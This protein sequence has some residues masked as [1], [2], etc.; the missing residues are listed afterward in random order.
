MAKKRD[1][2]T[3]APQDTKPA[4]AS[5][6]TREDLAKLIGVL[7]LDHS[8]SQGTMHL[9]GSMKRELEA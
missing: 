7:L 4:P 9:L 6:A 8:I 5:P 1:D 3:P 2:D